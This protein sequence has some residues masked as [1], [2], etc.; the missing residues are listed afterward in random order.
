MK[1]ELAF[2]P[3]AM[4]DIE[5][6]FKWYEEQRS[7]LGIEFETAVGRMLDLIRE[8]PEVAPVA[9]RD[10]RRLLLPRFPYAIYYRV[11]DKI[12]IRGCL[13]LRRAPGVWRRRA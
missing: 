11:A 2:T 3:L 5:R 7:G 13:H 1:R 10:L 12:E 9:H 4:A 8:M 6:A